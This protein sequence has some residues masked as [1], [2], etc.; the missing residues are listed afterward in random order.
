MTET[1]ATRGRPAPGFVPAVAL[2]LHVVV[3]LVFYVASGLVAPLYAIVVLWIL[4]LVLLGALIMLWRRRSWWV[5]A[6]PAA[7]F[8]LWFA[9]LSLGEAVFGWTA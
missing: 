3:G 8:A 4:W 2:V 5:L 6:V 9:I 1:P 7:A